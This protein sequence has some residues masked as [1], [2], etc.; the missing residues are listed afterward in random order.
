MDQINVK[1]NKLRVILAIGIAVLI[2]AYIFAMTIPM[3]SYTRTEPKDVV[4]QED[5][6]SFMQYLWFVYEYPDLTNDV[7]PDAYAA[8]LGTKYSITPTIYYPLI[9]F[10]L[11][12]VS[13]ALL[14][15][16]Y[17]K[18]WPVLFPL[19]WSIF[20]LIGA[21]TSPVLSLSMMNPAAR[22]SL[23]ILAA[24]VLVVSVVYLLVISI[25]QLR[26]EIA[27]REKL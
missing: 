6:V 27:T 5:E 13:A 4:G 20:S 19:V 2:L 9:S 8:E 3:V 23:I 22:L 1:N 25:P 11:A 10:V 24:V 7:L 14:L 16:F 26:Y 18:W 21:L 12:F 17:K 15:I